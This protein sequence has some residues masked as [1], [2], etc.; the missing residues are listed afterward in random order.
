MESR[1]NSR[2]RVLP[3]S[4]GEVDKTPPTSKTR[5]GCPACR[6][7]I[8]RTRSTQQTARRPS[9]IRKHIVSKKNDML[10]VRYT[11]PQPR[12][13]YAQ[14]SPLE[15]VTGA[16]G[17]RG[18]FLAGEMAKHS[19][20]QYG[21]RILPMEETHG[22]KLFAVSRIRSL[23]NPRAESTGAK[24]ERSIEISVARKNQA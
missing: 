10:N 11:G 24:D 12:L 20:I 15:T 6:R 2:P 23:K 9:E 1:A 22:I 13:V 5:G 8:F 18:R 16:I 3:T 17:D 19:G 21:S 7:E 14:S 4:K